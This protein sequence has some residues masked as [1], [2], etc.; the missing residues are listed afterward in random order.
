VVAVGPRPISILGHL[1][2]ER[3]AFCRSLFRPH[4]YDRGVHIARE[5]QRKA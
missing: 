2:A 3:A 1:S 4:T 5:A